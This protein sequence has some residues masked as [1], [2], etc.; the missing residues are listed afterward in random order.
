M[1]PL[2]ILS[3]SQVRRFPDKRELLSQALDVVSESLGTL[4]GN[5]QRKVLEAFDLDLQSLQ[6]T[7]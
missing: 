3:I 5:I 7:S 2:Q 6:N 1:A 4:I